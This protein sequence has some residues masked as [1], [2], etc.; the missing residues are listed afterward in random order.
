M[1]LK[2]EKPTVTTVQPVPES[3]SNFAHEESGYTKPDLMLN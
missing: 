2:S 1:D 3:N